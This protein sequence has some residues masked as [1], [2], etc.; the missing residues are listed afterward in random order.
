MSRL[1][2]EVAQIKRS[3]EENADIIQQQRENHQLQNAM[4]K[5]NVQNAKREAVERRRQQEEERRQ[6]QLEQIERKIEAETRV[7]EEREADV[8]RMEQEELELIQK[9]QNTQLMQK[10]AYDT[11]ENALSGNYDTQEDLIQV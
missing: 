4:L 5:Q 2:N 3:K 11:L 8:A 9:L 1:K 6:A 10:D 7:R